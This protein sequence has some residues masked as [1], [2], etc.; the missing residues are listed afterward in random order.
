M[1]QLDWADY[2]ATLGLGFLSGANVSV[3]PESD[4]LRVAGRSVRCTRTQFRYLVTLLRN[5]C[6]TVAHEQLAGAGG[7]VTPRE[8]NTM[9]VQMF[10][11]RRLLASHGAQL[12]IRTVHGAGYQARPA[13]P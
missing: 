7:R 9:K 8:Q 6:R 13:E 3:Y 10:Y 11:L 5:F 4:E 2:A 1:R 12:E